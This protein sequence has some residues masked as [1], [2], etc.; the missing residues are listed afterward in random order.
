MP[1]LMPPC[2]PVQVPWK[3][4]NNWGL[5][6]HS[7][8]AAHHCLCWLQCWLPT[9][10]DAGVVQGIAE[11]QRAWTCQSRD[12]GCICGKAHA[13]GDG[14]LHAQKLGH[15]LLKLLVQR[16]CACRFEKTTCSGS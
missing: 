16:C 7:T 4:A 9:C 2:R 11:H 10:H 1:S 12:A 6:K 3:G 8:D 14:I 13:K 15:Q 5:F